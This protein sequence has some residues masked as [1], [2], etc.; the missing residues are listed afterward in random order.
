MDELTC[1][2]L[3]SYIPGRG[4]YDTA[5]PSFLIIAALIELEKKGYIGFE[6]GCIYT[7]ENPITPSQNLKM[8][9]DIIEE[10]Q[11]ESIS[12]MFDFLLRGFTYSKLSKFVNATMD[13]LA[14]K[15]PEIQSKLNKFLIS[16]ELKRHAQ[17]N[18]I[19]MLSTGDMDG[20]I[21]LHLLYGCRTLQN[22][23]NKEEYKS[24]VALI[25]SGDQVSNRPLTQYVLSNIDLIR[26]HVLG[27]VAN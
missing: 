1:F 6:N 9:L 11:I 25:K 17:V 27:I 18:L 4:Y 3:L 19:N 14:K 2:S 24:A 10:K 12:K 15:Y 5:Q 22:H 26:G 7:Y 21:T 8:C 13:G 16:D 20:I 23:L